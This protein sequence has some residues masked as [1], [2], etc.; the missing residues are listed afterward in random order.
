MKCP[1]CNRE[2][3]SL[4]SDVSYGDHRKPYDRTFYRCGYDDW[5]VTVEIPQEEEAT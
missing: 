4:R 3:R 1:N 5:W 2:M